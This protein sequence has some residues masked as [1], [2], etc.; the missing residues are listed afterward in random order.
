MSFVM[1]WLDL[2]T[3]KHNEIIHIE[4]IE[5][6]HG[7]VQICAALINCHLP[8]EDEGCSGLIVGVVTV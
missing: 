8:V 4:Q 6:I 2:C 3:Y 1:I 7:F 5:Q